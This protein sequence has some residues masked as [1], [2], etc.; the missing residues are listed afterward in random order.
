MRPFAALTL[1]SN[2]R[3]NEEDSALFYTGSA[4]LKVHSYD[5]D[6]CPLERCYVGD[7]IGRY[8]PGNTGNDVRHDGGNP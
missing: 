3:Y 1:D 4:S 2:L 5:I 7:H 8:R 6:I